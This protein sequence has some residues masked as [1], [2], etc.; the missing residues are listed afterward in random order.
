MLYFDKQNTCL[1]T[2]M[3]MYMYV[4]VYVYMYMYVY[5]YVYVFAYV[6]A[7]VNICSFKCVMYFHVRSCVNK[8]IGIS[9]WCFLSPRIT[10]LYYHNGIYEKNIL[11]CITIIYLHKHRKINVPI[12]RLNVFL[13]FVKDPLKIY[14]PWYSFNQI[15]RSFSDHIL[16][17][18]RSN[19]G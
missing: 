3:Y 18:D 1:L 9:N 10:S 7:Y 12:L 8:D 5:V 14:Y 17:G 15:C 11:L 2:D 19:G 6:Y 4:Y 16:S 13:R